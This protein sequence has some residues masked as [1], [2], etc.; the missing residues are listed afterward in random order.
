MGERNIKRNRPES[1]RC[2]SASD[3]DSVVLED[4]DIIPSK[5]SKAV[6]VT[7]LS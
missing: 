3:N 1:I 5:N 6:I 4:F 2:A 7:E